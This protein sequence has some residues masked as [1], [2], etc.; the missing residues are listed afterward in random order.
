MRT[1]TWE[2]DPDK[3][4]ELFDKVNQDLIQPHLEKVEKQMLENGTGF[5][6][7]NAVSFYLKI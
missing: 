7:G 6:V 1:A 5:L 3:Q 2:K 4:K